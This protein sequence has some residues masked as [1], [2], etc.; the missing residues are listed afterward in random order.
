MDTL[1]DEWLSAKKHACIFEIVGING[2]DTLHLALPNYLG[3]PVDTAP[4][5]KIRLEKILPASELNPHPMNSVDSS[6]IHPIYYKYFPLD[7]GEIDT[8]YT[9]PIDYAYA[10]DAALDLSQTTADG[11]STKEYIG[12]DP[13]THH[14]DGTIHITHYDL[15]YIAGTFTFDVRPVDSPDGNVIHITNGRFR[16]M[17]P[18]AKKR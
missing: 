4:A 10:P 8:S 7:T 11:H 1:A 3:A 5:G 17:F 15:N 18:K 13:H 12:S 14:P 2:N 16:F 6:R 9:F